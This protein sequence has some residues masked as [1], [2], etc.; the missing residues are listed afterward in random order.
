MGGAD[1][2]MEKA[3]RD[4]ANGDYRWVAEVLNHL[5]YADPSNTDAK[6]LLADT[7][8]QLAYQTE[9]GTWRGLYLSAA[10]DLREG[11]KE[12]PVVDFSSP[13]TVAAM[14]FGLYLDGL[15]TRLDPAKSSS[16]VMGINL[17]FTD[18]KDTWYLVLEYGVL[19]YYE[20]RQ[21]SSAAVSLSMTVA[22][23]VNV[24]EGETTIEDAIKNGTVNL[25]GS[26]EKFDQFLS[27]FDSFDAWYN[28]V[29]PVE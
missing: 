19:Q 28:V 18:T 21:E 10:K 16:V 13:S 2:M 24:A 12:L 26:Q 1:A 7:N 20:H 22:D 3:T 9:A 17:E 29:T 25:T 4:F 23:F 15:S 27:L 8:E 11:V 14:P 5:V 6:N